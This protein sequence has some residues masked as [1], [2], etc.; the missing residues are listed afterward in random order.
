[1]KTTTPSIEIAIADD[2]LL[3]RK[4][5]CSIICAHK[6]YHV[7][8]EA[9]NGEELIAQLEQADTLPDICILDVSMKKMNGLDALVI[10]KKRWPS[11]KVLMLTIFNT[12]FNVM[13]AFKS[14]ANGFL[15]KDSN[16]DELFL[17]LEEIYHTGMYISDLIPGH[18]LRELKHDKFVIPHITEREMEFLILCCTDLTYGEIAEKMGIGLRTVETYRES[19]CGKFKVTSRAGLV[20]YALQNGIVPL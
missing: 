4:A 7:T 10:I 13:K 9:G 14:G 8:I 18:M 3:V 19:L 6:Q 11:V 1:M 16:P 15:L 2:H 20:T 5:L 12:H 17:A